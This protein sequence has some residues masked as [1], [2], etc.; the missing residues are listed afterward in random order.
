MVPEVVLKN[1]SLRM[2]FRGWITHH[3]AEIMNIFPVISGRVEVECLVPQVLRI[4]QRWI[5][6]SCRSVSGYSIGRSLEHMVAVV[7]KD[8][9]LG[10]LFTCLW[11]LEKENDI[12]T[13]TINS[14][15]SVKGR[16]ILWQHLIKHLSDGGK[17]AEE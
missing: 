15:H 1:Q 3:Q 16:E 13:S 12:L 14:R 8:F 17:M 7:I 6:L 10:C 2:G 5:E 9:G 11:W 4:S